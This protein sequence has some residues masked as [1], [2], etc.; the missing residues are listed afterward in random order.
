[1]IDDTV[2]KHVKHLRVDLN[3]SYRKIA[4]SF[5]GLPNNPKTQEFGRDLVIEAELVLQEVF[6]FEE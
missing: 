3:Y 6:D 4:E 1:M 2:A 5:K